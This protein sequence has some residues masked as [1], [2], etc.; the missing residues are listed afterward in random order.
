MLISSP[1][2]AIPNPGTLPVKALPRIWEDHGLILLV[3]AGLSIGPPSSVPSWWEFNSLFLQQMKQRVSAEFD[4]DKVLLREIADLDLQGIGVE[5]FS[6]H[7]HDA[8]AGPYWFDAISLG[9]GSSG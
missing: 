6:Q 9:C 2:V 8:F 3:G 7:V 1:Y 5:A 4:L